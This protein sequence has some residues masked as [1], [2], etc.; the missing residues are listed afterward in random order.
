MLDYANRLVADG[1]QVEVVYAAY[2]KLTKW[3]FAHGIVYRLLY[4]LRKLRGSWKPRW[5]NVGDRIKQR[6]VFTLSQFHYPKNAVFVATEIGTAIALNEYEIPNNRK[7]YF[8][9]DFEN[10][11]VSSDLVYATYRYK[12]HKIVVSNW[13]LKKV[14][15]IGETADVVYNGFDF[16]KF[17]LAIPPVKRDKYQIAF[18]YHTDKRKGIPVAFEAFR[19]VAAKHPEVHL[20]VFGAMKPQDDFPINAT[21]VQSPD[22]KAFLELYNSSAIYVAAS[23]VEGWGLTIGEA[24]QCG[25]AVACTDNQGYLEMAVDGVNALVSPVDN[26]KALA[27]NICRL[28]EDD[29]L[30]VKIA[31]NGMRSIHKFDINDSYKKFRSILSAAL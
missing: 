11:S 4:C 25:C 16:E 3:D 9:Q 26:A 2:N 20:A 24:M 17:H 6:F 23:E 12:M 15:E 31:E 13:L 18:M 5:M 14:E 28:I 21:F 8:I 30:R 27:E 7:Y 10:W 19:Q 29:E 22:Q 1:Y